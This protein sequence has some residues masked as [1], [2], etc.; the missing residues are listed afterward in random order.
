MST[1]LSLVNSDQVK[2]RIQEL[3]DAI[4]K[5]VPGY[6]SILREIH[7]NLQKD[8]DIVTLLTEEEIGIIVAGLSKHKNIVIATAETKGTKSKSLTS[9]GKKL[10]QIS[11]E[12][13]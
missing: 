4:A 6:V 1:S 2:A 13:L 9:T 5:A 11:L 8:P 10:N 3:Q 7:G 12:D